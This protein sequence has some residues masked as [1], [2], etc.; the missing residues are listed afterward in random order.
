M[1]WLGGGA[2]SG[3]IHLLGLSI[4]CLVGVAVAS[5]GSDDGDDEPQGSGGA[6]PGGAGGAGGVGGEGGGGQPGNWEDVGCEARSADGADVVAAG[7]IEAD[8]T[9]S[10]TVYLEGAVAVNGAALTIEEG[11]DI[12]AA[13]GA[14][15]VVAEGG[16]VVAEGTAAAPVR[17]CGERGA[18]GAWKGLRLADSAAEGSELSYVLLSDAGAEDSAVSLDAAALVNNLSVRNSGAD[19]LHAAIFA[20]GSEGL[21]V[22]DAEGAAVVITHAAAVTPFPAN[23][24]LTGNGDDAVYLRFEAVEVDARFADLGVPYVVEAT[25]LGGAGAVHI[26]A[27][28]R[29]LF[30]EGTSLVLGI[31]EQALTIEGTEESPVVF[32]GTVHTLGHFQGLVLRE[33]T[34]PDSSLAHLVIR[35]ASTPLSTR[36]AVQI[37]DLLLEANQGPMSIYPPGFA[38]GSSGV[39]VRGT[40]GFPIATY[41]V[42]VYRTPEQLVLEDNQQD[43][44]LVRDSSP[45]PLFGDLTLHESGTIRDVGVPYLLAETIDVSATVTVAP[46]VTLLGQ[47]AESSLRVYDGGALVMEGTVDEAVVLG[48]PDRAFTRPASFVTVEGTASETTSLAYVELSGGETCLTLHRP[49]PVE[50]SF[51]ADCSSF[52][53]RGNTTAPPGYSAGDYTALMSGNTFDSGTNGADESYGAF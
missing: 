5:C 47:W 53:I 17:F 28:S 27:G 19:G 42:A 26:E 2:A 4:A 46:G 1:T 24:D 7:D 10:G 22:T 44:V 50:N 23:G 43:V 31:E 9:W 39:T 34:H 25:V 40:S 49:V 41:G 8:T 15:L 12:V 18:A 29:F 14:A 20:E 45:S 6:A 48:P 16:T 36:A 21:N 37:E 13:D 35:D 32:E 3:R 38:Q 52:A 51:F 30:E 11:T 33:E